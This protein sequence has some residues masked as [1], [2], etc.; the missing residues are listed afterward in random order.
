[1]AEEMRYQLK[2]SKTVGLVTLDV[3]FAARLTGGLST[4]P[5]TC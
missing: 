3:I 1:M 5:G 2:D 4:G